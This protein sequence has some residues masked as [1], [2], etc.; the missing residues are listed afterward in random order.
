MKVVTD[1]ANAICLL[2]ILKEF[3]DSEHILT[4]KEITAKMDLI[5]GIKPDRRTIYSA[6]GVLQELGYDISAYEENK[7][8]YYLRERDFAQPEILLLTDAV[9]SFPFIPAK[10]SE[11]LIEKLQKQLSVHQRKKYRHLTLSR[12]NRKTDNR[13]VFLNLELLDEAISAKK[14]IS[15]VYLDYGLDKNL[16]P[17]RKEPYILNPYGMVYTNERY[18]LI[19]SYEGTKNI[20][21]YRIDFMR[22]IKMLET[23]AEK[24]PEAKERVKDSVFAFSGKPEKVKMICDKR[25]L[26]DVIDKFGTE[27]HLSDLD[28][29]HF[30]A[31]F[32]APP[33]G[34]KFWALQYLPFAEVTEPEWLRKEIIGSIM[35]NKYGIK[36]EEGKEDE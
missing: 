26:K 9:Y 36:I 31:T 10:Q 18:Y 30:T 4:M 22:D 24:N 11:Q 5:Y 6:V 21:L 23:A 14:Q 28:E 32:T 27:I 8:G 33:Y 3:S 15:C 2:E 12:Q 13:Q 17:R 35:K 16:H 20:S 34:I 29:M 19:C 7:I 1:R 25:V